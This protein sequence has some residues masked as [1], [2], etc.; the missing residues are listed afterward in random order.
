L[1]PYEKALTTGKIQL[2]NPITVG[3]EEITV[4]DFPLSELKGRD[5]VSAQEEFE[6]LTGSSTDG[7]IEMN[8]NFLAFLVSRIAKIPY[9]SVIDMKVHDFNVLTLVTQRFLFRGE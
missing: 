9:E 7:Q 5:I 2:R 4:L 3:G 1:N 8:K 6:V